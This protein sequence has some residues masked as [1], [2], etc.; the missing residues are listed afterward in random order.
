MRR[1]AEPGACACM[2]VGGRE[3]RSDESPEMENSPRDG[4]S[5]IENEN[6]VNIITNARAGRQTSKQAPSHSNMRTHTWSERV[7]MHRPL[8]Q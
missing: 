1:D 6:R 3:E 5:E 2:H 4:V 8:G 7:R